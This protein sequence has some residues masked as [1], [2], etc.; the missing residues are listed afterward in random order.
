MPTFKLF[1][2]VC[3]VRCLRLWMQVAA[4]NL[5][6]VSVLLISRYPATAGMNVII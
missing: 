1:R 4:V 2:V 3:S 6:P 5:V